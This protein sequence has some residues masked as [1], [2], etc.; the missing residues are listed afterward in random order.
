MAYGGLATE[1]LVLQF[2]RAPHDL[3]IRLAIGVLMIAALL[4]GMA[5]GVAVIRGWWV[6]PATAAIDRVAARAVRVF[7]FAMAG[8]LGVWSVLDA[9]RVFGKDDAV[10]S[11]DFTTMGLVVAANAV[12]AAT[13]PTA[14]N[15]WDGEPPSR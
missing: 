3:A 1:P 15:A 11:V 14:I 5:A 2:I 7:G 10:W 4:L 6:G 8:E 13:L 12:L 9:Y